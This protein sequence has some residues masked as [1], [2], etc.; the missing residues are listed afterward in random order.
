[1]SATIPLYVM[2]ETEGAGQIHNQLRREMTTEMVNHRESQE[3]TEKNSVSGQLL[4]ARMDRVRFSRFHLKVAGV[5]GVGTFLDA[6]DGLA[7]ASALTV[8]F[9]VLNIDLAASGVLLGSA[10]LGQLVGALIIGALADRFGRRRM[11]LASILIFG[12]LALVTAFAADFNSLLWLRIA[13]GIGLGAEVPVAAALF[14]ELIP[15]KG[16]GKIYLNYQNMFG[17]GVVFTPLIG[18]GVLASTPT[19]I[20]WRIV[21]GIG[22][23]P[24]ILAIA[25]W[26]VLPESPRW[27]VNKG[28]LEE[29]EVVV[30]R[31]ETE[32]GVENDSMTPEQGKDVDTRST[33]F[34]ELFSPA[35]RS[36]TFLL[37]IMFGV[38]YFV[39]YAF[40]NWL[41]TMYVQIGGLLPQRSL[42]LSAANGVAFVA[43]GYVGAFVIDR[44]GRRPY[45]IIAFAVTVAGAFL[46]AL[47]VLVVGWIHWPALFVVTVILA[48]GV[49]P[50]NIGC[51]MYATELFPT[52][53]RGWA[54]GTGSGVQRLASA[55]AP[56]SVGLILQA[57]PVK[58]T[59]VGIVFG[60]LGIVAVC[61]M[62]AFVC[63]GIETQNRTLE[64]SSAATPS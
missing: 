19:D 14:N 64:A 8:A 43:S 22:A 50:I 30:A 45:F 23:L 5:L 60:V 4:V 20:G 40:T 57:S 12:V 3:S 38:S 41:P 7:M 10:F 51:F 29:A 42:L 48:V 63:L 34:T 9:A 49:Y 55:A 31:I 16:R 6:Y 58:S 56:I 54:A 28:R 21:L 37:W 2:L 18:A 35:Y 39:A 61:G 15:S 47:V 13:Q 26:R 27:L 11:F 44:I 17:W 59:G 46:G 62:V 33:Q 36:R 52:R 25:A 32:S 53:I 24:L 1:M